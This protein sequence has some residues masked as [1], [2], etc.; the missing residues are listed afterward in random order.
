MKL[1]Y[2]ANINDKGQLNLTDKQREAIKSYLASLEEG[3]RV[4]VTIGKYQEPKT[5]QQLRYLHWVFRFIGE[6]I[7]E[8][9]EVIKHLMKEQFLAQKKEVTYTVRNCERRVLTNFLPSLA[10]VTKSQMSKFI[11]DVIMFCANYLKIAVPS[12]DEVEI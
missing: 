8:Q 11:D 7:G 6:E 12:P 2:L 9:P 1:R 4:E 3:C 10:D 5:G